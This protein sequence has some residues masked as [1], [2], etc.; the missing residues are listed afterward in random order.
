MSS[1]KAQVKISRWQNISLLLFGIVLFFVILELGL[2]FGGFIL[3]SL[4]E[5]RNLESIKQKATYRILCMGESTTQGQY[6]SYLEEILNQRSIGIKFSVIDKGIIGTNTKAIVSQLEANLDKYQPDIVVT[7]MGINDSG[8]H[9]PHEAASSSRI[10]L[11]IESLR[12]YKLAR[13]LWLH[14]ITKVKEL[15]FKAI[16]TAQNK[17]NQQEAFKKTTKL[18]PKIGRAIQNNINQGKFS[19]AEQLYKKALELN[20]KSD[21]ACAGLGKLYRDQGKFSEA[22]QLYKKALEL[23]PK[24]DIAYAGLG[25]LYRDQGKFSEAELSYKKA[26]ELN[27]KSDIA[28]AG[29][30]KLYKDHGKLF[31]A[32]QSFKKT[33]ELNPK[34]DTA[35]LGLGR[36]YINQGKLSEAEELLKKAFELNPKNNMAYLGLG[37]LYGDQGKF[38]EAEL[39]YKKAL[40]LNI[41]N[42]KAYAGLG[43]LYVDQGRFSEAE[44]AYK[45]ALELNPEIDRAYGG[46][47]IVYGEMGNYRLDKEY[48]GKADQLRNEYYNPDTINDYHR[49]KQILDKRKKIYIC[50]QYPIRSIEPLKEIFKMQKGV[51]FVDNK[52]IFKRAIRREGYKEYFKDAFG[53]DFGHC[54]PKGNRLLAENI[55]KVI[56]KELFGKTENE[57]YV[58]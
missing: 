1:G 16:P 19:E 20:P 56:I 29:L 34:N 6:P 32:E 7:M 43:R 39:V 50:V 13:L 27:P 17:L 51:I 10:T 21:I 58:K 41:K 46:L 42:D 9:M 22:E 53:G 35:C 47:A 37:R 24:S 40:E 49:L 55:A 48:W 23:N 18:I 5:H 3:F 36:L 33:L 57:G 8:L 44:L 14:I 12:V 38:P 15:G 25:K 2:R 28:Y 45:K 26:I 54:T 4:Q 31:E 11:F 52:E 30:G